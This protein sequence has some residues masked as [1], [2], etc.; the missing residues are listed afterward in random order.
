M[1]P[2]QSRGLSKK[3][4]DMRRLFVPKGKL[5]LFRLI[6]GIRMG[7]M[8]AFLHTESN[9]DGEQKKTFN[10]DAYVLAKKR[11]HAIEAQ[12]AMVMFESRHDKWKAGG[13]L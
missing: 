4:I 1:H 9:E 8:D 10:S 6:Q 13:P 3:V 2:Y 11:I 7:D 12:K 5:K